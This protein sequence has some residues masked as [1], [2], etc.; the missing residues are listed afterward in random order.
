MRPDPSGEQ[1]EQSKNHDQA[2]HHDQQDV[3]DGLNRLRQRKDG[4]DGR[5]GIPDDA[6]DQ[7]IDDEGDE[8]AYHG[9]GTRGGVKGSMA[10]ELRGIFPKAFRPFLFPVAQQQI[11]TDWL[12]WEI[13][14]NA[15]DVYPI[16]QEMYGW[17]RTEIMEY[18]ASQ[19]EFWDARIAAT[20]GMPGAMV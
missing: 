20:Y 10:E 9:W 12:L 1:V 2:Q 3:D 18:C 17:R 6:D 7:Q 13:L 4:H 8:C 14:R 16:L 19:K 5:D 11:I 15:E